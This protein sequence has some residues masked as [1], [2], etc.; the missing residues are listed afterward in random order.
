VVRPGAGGFGRHLAVGWR[1][2]AHTRRS[3]EKLRPFLFA[4]EAV[5]VIAVTN[6]TAPLPADWAAAHL[7]QGAQWHVEKPD[8]RNDGTA[9]LAAATALGAD[10]LAMGAYRHGRLVERILGGVTSD[11]LREATIPVLMHV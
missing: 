1:D 9:L 11:V 2:D 3:L 4:A 7:P 10:G 8:G 6:D 5:S